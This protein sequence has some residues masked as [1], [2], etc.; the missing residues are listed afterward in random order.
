MSVVIGIKYKDG[1][2]MAADKQATSGTTKSDNAIKMQYFEGSKSCMGVVGY[3]RDCNV[4]RTIDEIVAP[5][6]ILQKREI[7]DRYVI[8]N[9][10]PNLISVMTANKR[11]R[12]KGGIVEMDSIMMYSTPEKIFTIGPD[13]GVIESDESFAAIGCGED[14]VRGYLSQFKDMPRLTKDEAVELLT[15]AIQIACEKDVYINER[16]DVAFCVGEKTQSMKKCVK[17]GGNVR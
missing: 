2:V 14:K 16:I 3:L 12:D 17:R 15:K 11:V 6:D 8:S 4:I 7:N 9:I 10:I 5:I 13:F 1:V